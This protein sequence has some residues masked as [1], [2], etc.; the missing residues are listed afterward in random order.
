MAPEICKP[1]KATKDKVLIVISRRMWFP[2]AVPEVCNRA[3]AKVN[4]NSSGEHRLKPDTIIR[5]IQK[6]KSP[7]LN[8]ISG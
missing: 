4:E 1:W 5:I 2:Q 7:Y 6:M 8:M 3:D